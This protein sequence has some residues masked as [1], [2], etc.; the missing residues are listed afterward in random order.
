MTSSRPV[1][2]DDQIIDVEL[3]RNT[4]FGEEVI[5]APLRWNVPLSVTGTTPKAEGSDSFVNALE[6]PTMEDENALP[7]ASTG[8]G[9]P[10]EAAVKAAVSAAPPGPSLFLYSV[11]GVGLCSS[12]FLTVPF[13]VFEP[14]LEKLTLTIALT[15]EGMLI[16]LLTP[17]VGSFC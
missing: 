15:T 14:L 9:D 8:I 17:R 3:D 13:H 2:G 16:P 6:A 7:S 5:T 11:L 4:P 12:P 1:K 10:E